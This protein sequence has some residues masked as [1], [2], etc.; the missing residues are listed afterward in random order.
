MTAP[1]PH[2]DEALK[3]TSDALVDL[4]EI[5]IRTPDA[6]SYMRFRDGPMGSSTPWNGKVFDHL[7]CK[8]TGWS[9]S[10][11][12]EKARP[13]LQVLNPLGAFNDPVFKGYFD[14]AL[15]QR[16]R[17]LR[18][19]IESNTPLY[20]LEVWFISRPKDLLAGQSVTFECRA[21]SDGPDQL[22]PA[23]SYMPPE[24]P[25]TSL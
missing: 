5:S 13:Q 8:F 12:D 15:L 1:V 21:L 25:M 2:V 19:H 14:N 10:S 11:E 16:Y 17:V 3:L 23:R 9:R 6:T 22:V 20:Q 4:W 24:Y 18:Q 7:P